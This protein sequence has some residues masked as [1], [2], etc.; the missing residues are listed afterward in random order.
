MSAALTITAAGTAASLQDAGR[1]GHRRVGVPWSGTLAPD[2]LAVA[3]RLVGN[4]DGAPAIECFSGGQAFAAEESAVRVAVAGEADVEIESGGM[5]RHVPAWQSHRLLCGETL[6]IRSVH[7]GRVVLLGVAGIDVPRVLGSASAHARSG[8]GGGWLGA[9]A[10]IECAA[11]PVQPEWRL[12]APPPADEAPIRVI[13][14]PQRDHFT[15]AAW[16]TFLAAEYRIGQAADRMGMR[17]EGP[18]LQH[19]DAASRD[20]VSD[21]VIPGAI[22]VPGH[23]QPIVLLADAQTTGGYPK[24]ATVISADLQRLATRRPGET[25]RFCAVDASMG[26]RAARE[27]AGGLAERLGRLRRLTAEGI[28]LAALYPDNE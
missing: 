20:I 4:A 25:M 5:I 14:G 16:Q 13:A 9:G 11:A 1:F 15:E 6:R 23:G 24:I 18:T 12:D 7:D 2:L 26:E 10:R 17:L 3:N 27:A 28:D 22:Q 8:L 21:A 19:R